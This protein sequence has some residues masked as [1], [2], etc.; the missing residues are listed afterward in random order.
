[1]KSYSIRPSLKEIVQ[2]IR[3]PQFLI[4][5]E[6]IGIF[7]EE[8]ESVKRLLDQSDLIEDFKLNNQDANISFYDVQAEIRKIDLQE[9]RKK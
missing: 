2:G 8:E 9:E 5:E 3:L 6:A 4:E 1:M 7:K